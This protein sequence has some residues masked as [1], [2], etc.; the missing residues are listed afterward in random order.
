[1]LELTAAEAALIAILNT[2]LDTA[3]EEGVSD[4]VLAEIVEAMPGYEASKHIKTG[5]VLTDYSPQVRIL[6]NTTIAALLTSVRPTWT[7]FTLN[8]PW[9]AYGSGSYATPGYWLDWLGNLHFRGVVAGG[10]EFTSIATLSAAFRPNANRLVSA[11]GMIGAATVP[12]LL[13]ISASTG[14][15]TTNIVPAGTYVLLNLDGL[16]IRML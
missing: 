8:A 15:I 7:N 16:T 1:M 13:D 14:N 10:T 2:E 4:E 12:V 5:Q 11:L 9:A 6:P 3:L